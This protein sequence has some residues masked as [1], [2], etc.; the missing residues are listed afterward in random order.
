MKHCGEP[1]RKDKRFCRMDTTPVL[2]VAD[3]PVD[4]VMEKVQQLATLR[5]ALVRLLE[6]EL[7]KELE[8]TEQRG[9]WRQ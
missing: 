1:F 2:T 9:E 6:W 8:R 4:R 7:D 5:P 3:D